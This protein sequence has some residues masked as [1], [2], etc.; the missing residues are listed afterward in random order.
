MD[1]TDFTNVSKEDLNDQIK[2]LFNK[3]E[4]DYD[5]QQLHDIE[6]IDWEEDSEFSRMM[7]DR[8]GIHDDGDDAVSEWPDIFVR[9]N[10]VKFNLL[11]EIVLLGKSYP[12]EEAVEKEI[13]RLEAI[14]PNMD[15][16]A[17]VRWE[18]DW[19][20]STFGNKYIIRAECRKEWDIDIPEDAEEL[21]S[22]IDEKSDELYDQAKKILK[23]A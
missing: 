13:E 23:S 15:S 1:L 5:F 18:F 19:D 21:G 11:Q 6:T 7:I 10:N 8:H 17:E 12:S 20:E 4:E 9:D 2:D 16:E 22:L 14:L 3:V